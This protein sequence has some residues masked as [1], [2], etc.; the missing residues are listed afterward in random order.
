M[1]TRDKKSY[2]QHEGRILQYIYSRGKVAV[3]QYVKVAGMDYNIGYTLV[4]ADDNT[5]NKTCFNG[6][7]SPNKRDQR[8]QEE[9]DIAFQYLLDCLRENKIYNVDDR[10]KLQ[11]NEKRGGAMSACAF[12]V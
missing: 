1:R 12:S 10:R 6:P 8:P 11:G 5:I 4:D 7:L 9:Y 2:P 3:I